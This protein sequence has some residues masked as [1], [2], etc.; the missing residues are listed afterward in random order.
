MRL[1]GASLQTRPPRRPGYVFTGVAMLSL[2]AALPWLG[3]RT[4]AAI[5]AQCCGKWSMKLSMDSHVS[6]VPLNVLTGTGVRR[7]TL[8][9]QSLSGSF[10][11]DRHGSNKQGTVEGFKFPSHEN[12]DASPNKHR[13]LDRKAWRARCTTRRWPH[14][15][16]ITPVMPFQVE[17]FTVAMKTLADIQ[18]CIQLPKDI[19]KVHIPQQKRKNKPVKPGR[20]R[21]HCGTG[22]SRGTTRLVMCS[23]K[24]GLYRWYTLCCQKMERP[25][26]DNCT[27]LV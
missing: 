2:V 22:G 9:L 6:S 8:W 5:L 13:S 21:H 15:S 17:T 20:H 4:F 16:W 23:M 7:G 10:M 24:T 25:L 27:N 26:V 18:A 19:D 11:E 1:N 3:K 12:Y 14:I